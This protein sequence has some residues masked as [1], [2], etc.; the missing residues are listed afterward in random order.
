MRRKAAWV[1][2]K[3]SKV[4]HPWVTATAKGFTEERLR[5]GNATGATEVRFDRFALF[6]DSAVEVE[7]SHAPSLGTTAHEWQ[8]RIHPNDRAC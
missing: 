1:G 6:I 3:P 8:R 7:A 4:N 5:G 2:S